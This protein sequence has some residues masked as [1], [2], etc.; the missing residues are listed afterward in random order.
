[1]RWSRPF[2]ISHEYVVSG[3][4]AL[5]ITVVLERVEF[6]K[7]FP[8]RSLEMV[9]TVQARLSRIPFQMWGFGRVRPFP[10]LMAEKLELCVVT[11]ALFRPHQHWR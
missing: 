8:E 5:T 4:A 10:A 9:R 11:S 6:A 7:V 3:P 2:S 1:M